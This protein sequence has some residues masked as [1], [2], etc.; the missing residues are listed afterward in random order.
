ML[1][2]EKNLNILSSESFLEH[3]ADIINKLN[4]NEIK[5]GLSKEL[6]ADKILN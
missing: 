6:D 4:F 5:G 2:S 3:G 1:I